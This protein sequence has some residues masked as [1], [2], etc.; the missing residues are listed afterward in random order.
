MSFVFLQIL[1]YYREAFVSILKGLAFFFFLFTQ[2]KLAI[3]VERDPEKIV[4]QLWG[5]WDKVKL[6][7]QHEIACNIKR[8]IMLTQILRRKMFLIH[9]IFIVFWRI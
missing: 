1:E 9:T 3:G 7:L 4:I 8:K 6:L 5:G 2:S